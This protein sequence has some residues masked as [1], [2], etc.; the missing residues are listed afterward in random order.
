MTINDLIDFSSS[1]NPY[2]DYSRRAVGRMATPMG[3]Y[4]IVGLTLKGLKEEFGLTG[5]EVF[6]PE[7]QDQFFLH[8]F[9]KTLDKGGDLKAK[10]NRLRGVW[11]GFKYVSD[12][13]LTNAIKNI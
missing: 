12:E 4:A 6:S 3:K 2:A 7:L 11:E 9:H 1:S 8:L 13:E 5:D 10:I